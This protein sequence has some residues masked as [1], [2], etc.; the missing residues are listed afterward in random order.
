[1][2]DHIASLM[3]ELRAMNKDSKTDSKEGSEETSST[4]TELEAAERRI[5]G[6]VQDR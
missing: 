5:K 6:V 1:M 4:S 2:C 3:S